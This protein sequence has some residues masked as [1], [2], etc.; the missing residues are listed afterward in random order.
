MKSKLRAEI[1][2]RD[3]YRI[4]A[5][6]NVDEPNWLLKYFNGISIEAPF[7]DLTDLISLNIKS[8]LNHITVEAEVLESVVYNENDLD[9]FGYSETII[10]THK[11]I[12]LHEF[13]VRINDLFIA[14]QISQPGRIDFLSITLF[15]DDIMHKPIYY[16]KVLSP[17]LTYL[18]LDYGNFNKMII[19]NIEFRRVW[20]WLINQKDFWNETPD[21]KTG[22]F[23]N[24]FR[25]YHYD[26]S[27]LAYMWLAM[28]LESILVTNE[29]FSKV[30]ISGKLK[31]LFK[32]Y[33]KTSEIDKFVGEFYKLRSK[34]AHGKQRLFRPTLLHD[35]LDSVNEIEKT[36]YKN[37][38]FAY[39][40]IIYCIQLMIKTNR[41][42]LEFQEEI[43]Y[44]L[45]D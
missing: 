18:S 20:K 7:T 36:F 19:D 15:L 40:S 26:S 13:E 43:I 38:V 21:S 32:H 23:L 27:P 6:K 3:N 8:T 30:Q 5:W 12:R 37:G 1:E 39:S 35:A 14:L 29:K 28:A 31:V 45:L 34:I 10:N 2:V 11:R 42:N 24:Y 17:S 41:N 9:F 33:Y 44:T 4:P 22:I 16:K 25:Y